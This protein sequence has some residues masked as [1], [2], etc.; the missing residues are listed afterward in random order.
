M[1]YSILTT[2][3]K[4]QR[5]DVCPRINITVSG[6]KYDGHVFVRRG[7]QRKKNY[8]GFLSRTSYIF[9]ITLCQ[10]G[11]NTKLVGNSVESWCNRRIQTFQFETC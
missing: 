2:R 5:S 6:Y 10:E 3:C 1:D 9:R 7:S 8:P 4:F 11:Q